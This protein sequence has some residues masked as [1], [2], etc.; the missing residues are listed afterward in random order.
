MF[1]PLL[2]SVSPFW[3]LTNTVARRWLA[4]SA[5]RLPRPVIS[6]G[7]IVA[8]GVGKT[9]LAAA[10]AVR[11]LQ[12]KKRVV[13]ASRGYGSRWEKIGGVVFEADTAA[14]LQYP[15]EAQVLLRKAPGVA[16]AVGGD[17]FGVL[18]RYWEELNPDVVLL[19]DGFQHFKLARDLDILVHDFSVR[20][21]ILREWPGV[22][23]R[24]QVRVALSD[25]PKQW[26][27]R[28][29]VRARYQLTGAVD[30]AGKR[31]GLPREALAFCGLGNPARFRKALTD[32]GVSL[33]GFRTFRDHMNYGEHEVRE[34]AKWQARVA[35]HLPILTTL[36]DYVKLGHYTES[37]GGLAGFEPRWVELSLGF[38]ENE[39]LLW[40]AVGQA[41][42]APGKR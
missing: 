25:V 14:S 23:D 31:T 29:W 21:P 5:R 6:I 12:E 9:E 26:A 24:A 35:P 38:V 19:D 34:L 37:Q 13:V 36:K 42:E 28:P 27:R 11:L 16:V 17:R 18:T 10:I 1:E 32:A 33:A 30:G 7:N 2:S 8:G 40:K 39:I 15:D 4:G 22:L 3:A 41:V 20:W